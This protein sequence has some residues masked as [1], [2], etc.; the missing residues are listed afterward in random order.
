MAHLINVSVSMITLR[1]LTKSG[2]RLLHRQCPSLASWWPCLDTLGSICDAPQNTWVEDHALKAVTSSSC[3]QHILLELFGTSADAKDDRNRRDACAPRDQQRSQLLD[4]RFEQKAP[5]QHIQ[6]NGGLQRVWG[7]HP[8][9]CAYIPAGWRGLL[10][11]PQ[12]IFG[13]CP[14]RLPAQA[15]V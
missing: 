4:S 14:A 9:G 15:R 7:G 1:L 2:G 5:P 6:A 13:R 3:G 11:Q 8:Y 12:L 10:V